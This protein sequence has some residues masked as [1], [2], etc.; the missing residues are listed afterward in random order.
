MNLWNRVLNN[1]VTSAVLNTEKHLQFFGLIFEMN[2]L[3]ILNGKLLFF[4]SIT[5][6]SKPLDIIWAV[7][8]KI[9]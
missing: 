9:Y 7:E 1:Y 3:K 2:A 4:E 6:F 5:S 8:G